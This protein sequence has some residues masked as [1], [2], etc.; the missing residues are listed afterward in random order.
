MR[1]IFSNFV[2]FS[3]SPNFIHRWKKSFCFLKR[4]SFQQKYLSD[5]VIFLA[6]PFVY[7]TWN[8]FLPPQSAFRLHCIQTFLVKKEKA[9]HCSHEYERNVLMDFMTFD[10]V[11]QHNNNTQFSLIFHGPCIQTKYVRDHPFKTSAFFKG[12]GSNI[13]QICRQIVVKKTADGGG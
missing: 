5:N 12:E 2:C 9:L 4:W 8:L 3:E 1:K 10:I 13:G 6:L 11:W 7:I